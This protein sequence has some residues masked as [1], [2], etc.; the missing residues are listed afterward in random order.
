[1]FCLHTL[2]SY[3]LIIPLSALYQIDFRKSRIIF[4]IILLITI[5]MLVAYAAYRKHK[6]ILSFLIAFNN[7][8]RN[9]LLFRFDKAMFLSPILTRPPCH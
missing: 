5:I 2:N 4:S 7:A 3:V 1:M 8:F 9:I 6:Y